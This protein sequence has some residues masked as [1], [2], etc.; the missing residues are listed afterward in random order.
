M[1]AHFAN[2]PPFLNVPGKPSIPW[3]LW[4][5]IF[6]VHLK[7]AG[8]S[9]W[10]DER[11]ASALIS[12]LGI[13]GQRK[14]FAAQEQLEAQGG[15]NATHTASTPT[16]AD[17]G[18]VSTDAATT[19]YD[20][21][22]QFL[23]GLFAESTNVLAERHLFTSRKQLPGET[24]LDFVTAL[25]E[26]ALSCKFGATYDDRVRDQVIHGVANAHVWAKLLS[27]GEALTLQKAEEVGRDLEALQKANAAFEENERL[28]DSHSSYGG[29]IQCVAAA[30]NGGSA[31][32]LVPHVTQHGGGFPPGAGGRVQDGS[33]GS[34]ALAQCCVHCQQVQQL[35]PKPQV[36][37]CFRCGKLGHLATSRN[38]PAKKKICQFCCIKGHFAAV[39]RKRRASVQEVAPVQDRASGTA[40]VLSVQAVPTSPRDLRIPVIVGGH[41]HM[42]LLVDTGA[43]AS[44]MTKKDFDMLFASKHRLLQMS[45]QLQ[46]FSKHR[47]P[48][49]GYF[50]TDLQHRGKHAFVTFYVTAH[51]TSLLG[52]DAIQQLGLL[53][54]GATLT[55]RLA[56]PVSSQL[57]AGVPPGFEHLPDRAKRRQH[58]IPVSAKL[59]RLPLALRQQDA[60]ELRRLQD[61]DVIVGG[62]GRGPHLR[63]DISN[64]VFPAQ[65]NRGGHAVQC[66][67]PSAEAQLQLPETQYHLLGLQEESPGY[68]SSP[69]VNAPNSNTGEG[70][71][72]TGF[73][74][75]AHGSRNPSS[76]WRDRDRSSKSAPDSRHTQSL[77]GGRG[78]RCPQRTRKPQ[79][80]ALVR[81]CE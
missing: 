37:P 20:T 50:R 80:T 27:Y 24:F 2:L 38:C 3:H 9:G 77:P 52:L 10:E 78:S 61:D 51:G 13:E 32:S 76:S 7:A 18:T 69:T 45:I 16:A 79:R 74:N 72:A 44:L 56:T 5:K 21:L 81:V 39:C 71:N 19:E 68:S 23:D 4:K 11:R 42:S 33:A 29:S 48:V 25:K 70:S 17:S 40:T 30:Q 22:L 12:V 54:D 67:S 46:D 31:A 1:A 73:S 34:T 53:I 28:L 49:L 58:I 65:A 6:Q 36:G 60:S 26:K 63:L 59:R 15:P 35:A 43:T 14:Y 55:C 47:I 57:P 66:D 75:P 62:R 8:G 41:S 64:Q